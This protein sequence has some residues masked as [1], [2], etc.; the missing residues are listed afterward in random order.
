MRWVK[1]VRFS[2]RA[3]NRAR[4]R[5][6]LSVSGVAV[7]IA[8]VVIL[9]GAGVGA[10]RALQKSLE[11][12]GENLL[13]VNA[14]RMA[15]DAL[16]G[17]GRMHETLTL[18]DW[19]RIKN[20]PTV[21]RAAPV[22]EGGGTVKAGARA[23]SFT[24]LGTTP[25]F[26]EAKK[27]ELIAG[28]FID[29]DD[30]DQRRRVAVVGAQVT[31]DLF[32]GEWAV[33]ETLLIGNSPFTIIGLLKRKGM[34]PD[35]TTDDGHIIVPVT[36]VQRR[37]QNI[38]YLA[39]IFVQA[40]SKQDLPAAKADI[41]HLLRTEHSI[42]RPSYTDDFEIQ[43]QTALLAT[44]K[45]MSGT[46]SNLT[47]GLAALALTLG[48]VGLLAVSLLSVRERYAEIGLRIAVGAQPRD[49]LVQFLMEAALL[50]LLGGLV[51]ICI[52]GAGILIAG[53]ITG[54]ALAFT[55]EAVAYPFLIS[56]AIAI[57]FGALPASRAARLDPIVALRSKG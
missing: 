55:W 19:E 38:D 4:L 15:T 56:L 36:T 50:A 37:M 22:A 17:A 27:F 52:G 14:G 12:L 21:K 13:A 39:R 35:G 53:Q 41:A 8:A 16:R 1:N 49:I 43:E 28:R 3:L 20:L 48:G 57:V 32:F 40:R 25:E 18:D 31:E 42:G 30:I 45:K 54:W 29:Q 33:G 46:F 44:Q 51:G 47:L 23:Q 2:L 26:R 24:V 10:D 7:G 6:L 34:N 11:R 5:A 9:I